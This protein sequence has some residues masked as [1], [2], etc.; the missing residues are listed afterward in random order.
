[1]CYSKSMLDL[2]QSPRVLMSYPQAIEFVTSQDQQG[3]L[4]N[5]LTQQGFISCVD[6]RR[7]K[8][9]VGTAG[10]NMG[11]FVEMLAAIEVVRKVRLSEYQVR[12]LFLWYISTFKQFYMHTDQHAL[13]G[14]AEKLRRS[15]YFKSDGMRMTREI[16]RRMVVK[17][18]W[19]SDPQREQL[20]LALVESSGVGCG[21]LKLMI[22]HNNQYEVRHELVKYAMRAFY[23][24]L[25]HLPQYAQ[26]L[27][28]KVLE[29][30]HY[31]QAVLML[32][33]GDED[34]RLVSS[35]QIP[36][37]SPSVNGQQ[38]F[39]RHPQVERALRNL[40]SRRI[41]RTNIIPAGKEK[42]F[43]QVMTTLGDDFLR[44]TVSHLALGLPIHTIRFKPDWYTVQD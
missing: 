5:E 12:N 33:V 15:V 25:W 23:T 37:I 30:D 7:G 3:L 1:M 31:E 16:I 10:G 14:V 39:V 28:L 22:R 21:H 4:A 32:Y 29:D 20:L 9:V 24:T 17:P 27:E 42:A 35:M 34:T 43:V 13:D 38:V 19:L 11:L 18:E 40:S 26:Y 36:L 44:E 8:P 6:G 41:A 2:N